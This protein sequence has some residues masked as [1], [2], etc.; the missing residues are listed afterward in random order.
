[1]PVDQVKY[2]SVIRK[3]DILP[4]VP[5]WM[6]LESIVPSEMNQRKTNIV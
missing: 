5:K 6:D 3:K 2:Y 4:F 1:M